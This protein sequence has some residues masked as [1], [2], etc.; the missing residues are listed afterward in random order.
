VNRRIPD[1]TD[2]QRGVTPQFALH[3][4]VPLP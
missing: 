3:G 2:L 4:K 1:I